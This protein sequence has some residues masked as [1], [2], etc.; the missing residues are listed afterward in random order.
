[1]HIFLCMDAHFFVQMKERY[2]CNREQNPTMY[3]MEEGVPLRAVGCLR[4]KWLF[5]NLG[6][7][8][9]KL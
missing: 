5:H 2:C 7:N 1:M 3:L 9:Y 6:I 4:E 8:V